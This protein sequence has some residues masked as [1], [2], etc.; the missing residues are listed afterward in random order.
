MAS[1]CSRVSAPLLFQGV[2]QSLISYHLG[3]ETVCLTAGNWTGDNKWC[4]QIN[5]AHYW[6]EWTGVDLWWVPFVNPVVPPPLHLL[7]AERTEEQRLCLLKYIS[8]VCLYSCWNRWPWSW[9]ISN[10]NVVC[11]DESVAVS[12]VLCA[13]G[14]LIVPF[15]LWFYLGS[16]NQGSQSMDFGPGEG[17]L[18]I[19]NREIKS[20][21]H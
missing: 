20:F 21:I 16:K 14:L 13:V 10:I 9:N 18:N 5:P 2:K 3:Q 4:E 8:E 11:H 19:S 7:V 1:A 6:T 17:R 15:F 12:M